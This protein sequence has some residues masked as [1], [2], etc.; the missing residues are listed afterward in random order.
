LNTVE[1]DYLSALIRHA[2]SQRF[3]NLVPDENPNII[4]INEYWQKELKASPYFSR[5]YA[6]L[7]IYRF[8]GQNANASEIKV[9][10]GKER[11]QKKEA[12]RFRHLQRN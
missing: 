5:K 10:G 7:I 12:G 11:I 9:E 3:N 4:E 8:P 1:P 2:Q 6:R